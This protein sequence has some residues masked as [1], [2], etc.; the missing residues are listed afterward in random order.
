CAGP[1]QGGAGVHVGR[2]RRRAPV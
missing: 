2:G 1:G